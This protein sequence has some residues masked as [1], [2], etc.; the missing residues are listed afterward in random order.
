MMELQQLRCLI[1]VLDTGSFTKAA[2]ALQV[3][4]GA[5]SHAVNGLERR[6]GVPLVRRGRGLATATEAGERVSVH[7]RAVFARLLAAEEEVLALRGLRA[8]RLR[9]GSFSSASTRLLPRL[10]AAYRRRH[11]EIE[12]TLREGNDVQARA[13]LTGGE[14]D[15]AFV[16][17]PADG[18]DV[19]PLAE[20]ELVLVL[21]REHRLAG[22]E[23]VQL[24][25][26]AEEPMILSTGGCAALVRSAFQR[27]GLE[28]REA[29]VTQEGAT[30]LAMVEGGLGVTLMPQLA[31]PPLPDALTVRPVSPAGRRRLGLATRHEPRGPAVEAFL[32]LADE[33]AP[34]RP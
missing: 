32:A 26:L 3:T 18:L 13:W 20:D 14:V 30:A 23:V 16:V 17:L 28:P 22:E 31:V 15:V 8:G 2:E 4:Q 6:L 9:V 24:A 12:V 11:P 29:G 27:H 10:L 34:G 19:M 5:V 7:A 33:Q 1:A 25:R 21:P